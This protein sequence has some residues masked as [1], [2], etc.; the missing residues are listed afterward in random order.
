[1]K[2]KV[3]KEKN[4]ILILNFERRDEE[5]AFREIKNAFDERADTK[6]LYD[7]MG[8]SEDFVE[9]EYKGGNVVLCYDIDYGLQPL[10]CDRRILTDIYKLVCDIL[11]AKNLS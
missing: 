6:T 1:M 10:E 11:T 5:H 7:I 8:P 4:S 2:A 9:Y 3:D